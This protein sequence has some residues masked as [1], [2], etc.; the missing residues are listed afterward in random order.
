MPEL[1]LPC[2]Q[3]QTSLLVDEQ[4]A[5]IDVLCPQCQSHLTLPHDLSG[6]TRPELKRPEAAG[7][8]KNHPLQRTGH[9]LTLPEEAEAAAAQTPHRTHLPERRGLSP[10]E[11]LRRMAALTAEP[12]AYDLHNV[13]TR[14]R[15]AFPCPVCHRP[16]W[17][18]GTEWGRVLVCEGCSSQLLAPDPATGAPAQVQPAEGGEPRQRTVLPARRH[19]EDPGATAPQAAAGPNRQGW[20]LPAAGET[21]PAG[22]LIHR[23]PGERLPGF[24]PG[25]EADLSAED[26]GNWGGGAARENSVVFRRT[27]TVAI[28]T[29]LL[30]AIGLTAYF[31]RSHWS[32][33]H[34]PKSSQSAGA[35]ENQVLHRGLAKEAIERYFK[36]ATVEDLAK[37]V[38]HPEKSLPRMKAYYAQGVPPQ[39]MEFTGDWREQ[40]NHRN[41]GASLIFTVVTLDG[42]K[43]VPLALEVFNDGRLPKLDWEHFTAWSETPWSEFIRTSSERPGDF[44]VEITPI[45]AYDGFYSDRLR[46]LAFRVSDRGDEFGYCRAY[47]ESGSNLARLLLKSVREARSEGR[48]DPKTGEGVAQVILRLR[49]LPEGKQFNQANIDQMISNEWLEP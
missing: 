2:P 24:S 13:D 12:A 5:G 17:I 26:T 8:R 18:S 11:E 3:C 29:L 45:D 15:T 1:I 23:L 14:G 41:S 43:S 20:Q 48:I 22:K 42:Q 36:A 9:L 40:H 25:H 49:F 30:G 21:A 32:P 27:L 19:M 28:I 35:E 33:P 44:R 16:V 31:I 10:E 39:K 47:C 4:Y 38:R 34:A 37:E 7:A 46:Y 6:A